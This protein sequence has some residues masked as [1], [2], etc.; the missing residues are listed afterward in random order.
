MLGNTYVAWRGGGAYLWHGWS[1]SLPEPEAEAAE[2]DGSGPEEG[3]AGPPDDA[4]AS[5]DARRKAKKATRLRWR[6][7]EKERDVA[8]NKGCVTSSPPWGQWGG[9]GHVVS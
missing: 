5:V 2:G 4:W 1:E 9:R 7:A 8:R 3:P 6:A